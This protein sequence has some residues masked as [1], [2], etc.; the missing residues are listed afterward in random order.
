MS[1]TNS[2]MTWTH[3]SDEA[4]VAWAEAG[5]GESPSELWAAGWS[6]ATKGFSDSI[7]VSL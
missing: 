5:G 7:G 4:G 3:P 2:A 6:A 1:R